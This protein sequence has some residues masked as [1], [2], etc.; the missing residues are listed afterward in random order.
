[1]SNR[2]A[3]V[4]G[5]EMASMIGN[6][7]GTRD[8]VRK[9]TDRVSEALEGGAGVDGI[10]DDEAETFADSSQRQR[11]RAQREKDTDAGEEDNGLITGKTREGA[12]LLNFIGW[13]DSTEVHSFSQLGR[14]AILQ[15][16]WVSVGIIVFLFFY[17][18]FSPGGAGHGK[19]PVAQLSK[20]AGGSLHM[21]KGDQPSHVRHADIY[22]KIAAKGAEKKAATAAAAAA[23][24]TAAGAAQPATMP[25]PP[26]AKGV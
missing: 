10:S 1:M 3:D 19:S 14:L 16:V 17:G 26:T 6:S 8:R 22:A 15:L 2:N 18:Y 4:G 11:T 7:S 20:T 5:V 13:G 25:A 12:P 21:D 9:T 24:T 23:A